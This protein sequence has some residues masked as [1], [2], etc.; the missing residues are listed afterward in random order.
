MAYYNDSED[1]SAVDP[2]APPAQPGQAGGSVISGQGAG[3]ATGPS[4]PAP[5]SGDLAGGG[6]S[7]G[8]SPFV[9]IK[10]YID[11]NKSQSAKLA[12]DT[13]GLVNTAAQ[14]ARD[15][16]PQQTELYN[17]AVDQNT[18]RID[19]PVFDEAKSSAEKV[20][21]DEA[22]KQ[23]F[24]KMRDA[25]YAGPQSFQGSEF[26]Q[27][28]Q[29]AFDNATTK[30]QN[31]K[32]EAG[33][34]QLLTDLQQQTRGK[35]NQSAVNLDRILLRGDEARG[36]LDQS[37]KS[38]EDLP[39][40]LRE[41]EAQSAAK[42][43]EAKDITDATR[44]AVRAAFTGDQGVQANLEKELTAR[45][46]PLEAQGK[47]EAATLKSLLKTDKAPTADQLK[48][49]G[50]SK[51]QYNELRGI[52][53][54]YEKV[55]E[56]GQDEYRRINDPYAKR[57]IN[58]LEIEHKPNENELSDLRKIKNLDDLS[59]FTTKANPGITAQQVA[60]PEEYAR[61]AALNSLMNTGNGFLNDPSKAGTA[62]TDRIDFQYDKAKESLT[63]SLNT[64]KNSLKAAWAK[65]GKDHE[66][67]I[68]GEEG[69]R[70]QQA[71]EGGAVMG[72]A[73]GTAVGG[74]VGGAIGAAVG[75]AVGGGMMCFVAGTP[76]LMA[77]GTYKFVQDLKIG[78]DTAVGG[79]VTFYGVG[80]TDTVIEYRGCM[81]SP[82]HAIFNGEFWARAEEFADGHVITCDELNSPDGIK[83]YPVSNEFHRLIT[84]NGVLYADYEELDA[85]SDL[86][87]KEIISTMNKSVALGSDTVCHRAI[88]DYESLVAEGTN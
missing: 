88:S 74:P 52:I 44:N 56:I 26:Y 51:K 2:N 79:K 58:S 66:A 7:S 42:A 77:D 33:Q 24:V 59:G 46:A 86:S 8:T 72:G 81:T 41:A 84:M 36:I 3:G 57:D 17:Q 67:F 6:G 87:D 23:T 55:R 49:L 71:E 80:I 76:I 45:I 63:Q 22:K 73:V 70:R 69:R 14:Q 30:A 21:A 34:G 43:S 65:L 31:T 13:A 11:A 5:A 15:T 39:V 47:K 48:V 37:V 61:Y 27:P 28:V 19:Q 29:Q 85:S 62:S 25:A 60:T 53:K 18:I 50:I 54:E 20:A 12:T 1:E 10:Q 9:G 4:T 64:A 78:D 68:K 75:G 32:T 16:V 40:I 82:S 35:V 83:V 38:Q